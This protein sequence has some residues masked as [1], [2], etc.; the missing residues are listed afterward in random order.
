MS[1][2]IERKRKKRNSCRRRGD[3]LER[4]NGIEKWE[5]DDSQ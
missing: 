2:I 5:L 3:R 1:K 4:R